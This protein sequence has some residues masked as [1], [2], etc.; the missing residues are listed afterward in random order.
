MEAGV[1]KSYTE[2]RDEHIDVL[3]EIGNIGAGN[4][5][6]SLSVLLDSDVKI[7]VPKVR[8]EHYKNVIASIGGPEEMITA[9]LVRFNGEANGVVL[10]ILSMKDAKNIANIL[11]GENETDEDGFGEMKLSAVKELGNILGSAYLGSVAALTEL[12]L[13][14]SVPYVAVDMAGAVLSA[15]IME[16]GAEDN[17]VMFIEEFLILDEERV[18]G[19]VILF[20]DIDSLQEIMDRLGLAV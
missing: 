14:I 18:R 9:V 10:F 5:A 2:L 13:S 15:P 8:I 19:N 17:K 6:T 1:I 7:T 4:A 20:T 3:S 11:V 12:K 16:Y